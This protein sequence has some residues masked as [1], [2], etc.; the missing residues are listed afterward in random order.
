MRTMLMIVMMLGLT[1][2]F[3]CQ[4][5]PQGGGMSR[6]EGF[7]IAVPTFTT[8]LKQGEIQTVTVSLHRGQYFKRDVTLDIRPSKGITV[9]PTSALVKGSDNPELQLRIT[10]ARDANLGEYRIYVQGTPETGESTSV[11]FKV[12]VVA[13]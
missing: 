8:E 9:E 5:S 3:G 7:K 11:D 10:A 12:K 13:P 4:T 6:D 1:V 2:V